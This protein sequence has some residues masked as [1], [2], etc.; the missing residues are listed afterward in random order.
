MPST[1]TDCRRGMRRASKVLRCGA[2]LRG[3]VALHAA[4]AEAHAIAGNRLFPGTLTFD[5]PAV[6]DE[7]D[8]PFISSERLPQPLSGTGRDTTI[9]GSITRLLWPGFAITADSNWTAQDRASGSATGFGPTHLSL[10]GQLFED[11]LH[12]TLLSG[13]LSWGIAGLGNPTILDTPDH[14]ITPNLLFGKGFGDFPN[15]LSW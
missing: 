8:F 10:K 5:D 4:A 6:I 13:S 12:E 3:R 2:D 14:V 11:D 1:V 9:N 15:Q 7:L